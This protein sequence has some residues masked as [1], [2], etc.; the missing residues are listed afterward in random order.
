MQVPDHYYGDKVSK[1]EQARSD[2]PVWVAEQ[3]M[4][5]DFLGKLPAGSR[6]LDTPV[7]TGRFLPYYASAGHRLTGL[8]ISTAMLQAAAAKAAG[9]N[10]SANFLGGSIFDLPFEDGEFDAVVCVRLLTWFTAAQVHAALAELS[11][12]SR[13]CVVVTAHT[14]K[15]VREVS[16]N[17]LNLARLG[18]SRIWYW[19]RKRQDKAMIR[20]H[21]K[22]SLLTAF[23]AHGLRVSEERTLQDRVAGRYLGWVLQRK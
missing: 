10:L 16:S 12:V 17:P 21:A 13:H 11:R 20:H 7:G 6:C 22:P 18:K 14:W 8:D 9:V 1:Y 23:D 2:S 3:R 5:S 4:L 15:G 19:R